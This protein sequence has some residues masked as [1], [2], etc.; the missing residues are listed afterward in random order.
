MRKDIWQPTVRSPKERKGLVSS[1]GSLVIRHCQRLANQC[2]SLTETRGLDVY[3]V[4]QQ[5]QNDF[6]RTVELQISYGTDSFKISC[7][8]LIDSGSPISFVKERCIPRKYL[9]TNL[10]H[11]RFCGLNGSELE[12]LGC[13]DATV[14]FENQKCN[15]VLRVV[16]DRTMQSQT[17]LGRDFMRPA[18]L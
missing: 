4:G 11:D 9:I 17:V 16:P 8:A 3:Y 2:K 1:A 15:V 10:E 12:V 6:R 14:I 18:K 13:V 5:Q 7:D